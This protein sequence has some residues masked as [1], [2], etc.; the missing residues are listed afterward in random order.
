VPAVL[1]GISFIWMLNSPYRYLCFEKNPAPEFWSRRSDATCWPDASFP[2]RTTPSLVNFPSSNHCPAE[3][4]P[5]SARM[6]TTASSRARDRRTIA[7][8]CVAL[9]LLRNEIDG[10]EGSA[11]F[12]WQCR[13][14]SA[15]ICSGGQLAI[16][17]FSAPA[18]GDGAFSL[19][20]GRSAFSS[21]FCLVGAKLQTVRCTRGMTKDWLVQTTAVYKM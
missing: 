11:G 18:A 20:T 5:W 3:A 21:C 17:A 6:V 14:Q 15:F 12:V 9:L 8:V 13:G 1:P 16:A 10:S 19:F 4:A 2:T 7:L